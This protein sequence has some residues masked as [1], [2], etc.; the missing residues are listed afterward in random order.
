ML[1]VVVSRGTSYRIVMSKENSAKNTDYCN[2]LKLTIVKVH[3]IAEGG[4]FMDSLNLIHN[5]ELVLI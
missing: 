3:L 4:K 1:V 5:P 2:N